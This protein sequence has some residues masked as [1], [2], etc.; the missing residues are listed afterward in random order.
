MS[1]RTSRMLD[2]IIDIFMNEY[3]TP[4]KAIAISDP[5]YTELLL[6]GL[7]VS[8]TIPTSFMFIGRGVKWNSVPIIYASEPGIQ[9]IT[10]E[11][12]DAM[13]KVKV[14][15][16][17]LSEMDLDKAIDDIENRGPSDVENEGPM[18]VMYS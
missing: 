5:Y 4:L 13:K 18:E 1:D 6:E 17:K 15:M 9:V 16:D 10:Q 7:K 12:Y 2:R 11:S 3:N 8:K 14:Y